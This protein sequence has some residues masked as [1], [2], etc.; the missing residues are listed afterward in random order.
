M[1]NVFIEIYPSSASSSSSSSSLVRVPNTSRQLFSF[2]RAFLSLY[3][4]MICMDGRAYIRI[5]VCDE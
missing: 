1:K 5:D 4:V 2:A 3:S